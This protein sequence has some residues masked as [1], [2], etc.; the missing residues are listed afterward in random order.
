MGRHRYFA[1]LFRARL[2]FEVRDIW[3]LSLVELNGV[4]PRQAFVRFLQAIKRRGYAKAAQT[5]TNLNGCSTHPHQS[6]LIIAVAGGLP[7]LAVALL[8]A[9][10]F[11]VQ[12]LGAMLAARREP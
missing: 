10:A 11:G 8:L 9:A 1:R 4:W 5:N 6:W 2:V 3:P 12:R 7:G